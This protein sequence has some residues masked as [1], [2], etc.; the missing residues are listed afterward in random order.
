MVTTLPGAGGLAGPASPQPEVD[1]LVFAEQV[2]LLHAHA[3]VAQATV[4]VNALVVTAVLWHASAHSASVT[5]LVVV[6]AVAMARTLVARRYRRRARAPGE[7]RTWARVFVAGAAVNGIGWGAAA[8]LFHQP[9]APVHDMFIAFVLGGMTAGAASSNAS[10]LPAFAAFALPALA[11]ITVRFAGTHDHIHAAMAFMLALFGVAVAAIAR[12]GSRAIVNAIRLRLH[13]EALLANLGAAQAHLQ[14]LNADLERRVAERTAELERIL[15][16]RLESEAR[17][18]RFRALLDQTGDAILVARA[19]DLTIVDANDG[20]C[21]LLGARAGDLVGQHLDALGVVPS[22]QG[23]AALGVVAAIRPSEV[24][25]FEDRR[26]LPDGSARTF[27]MGL[28][29]R[30][31]ERERYVLL[32]ARDVSTRKEMEQQLA[33]AGLLASVGS[34]AAGVAHEIN[35]PLAYVLA[36]LQHLSA[37]IDGLSAISREERDALLEVA[38]EAL[39]GAR[40]ARGIVRDLSSLAPRENPAPEPVDLGDVL[41]PC[42]NVAMN[43]IRHRATLVRELA[44]VPA[45][46]GD[47]TRL[48]QVFLNLLVNAA[49]AVPEGR[50]ESHRITVRSRYDPAEGLVHV[51]VAD[52]GT[53][54]P[55]A[56]LGRIFEPFFTTKP[57]GHGT[58]L[59]LSICRGIVAAIGGRIAVQSREGEGS[60]FTVSLRAAPT[61]VERQEEPAPPAEE[62][63]LERGARVL[64]IDDDPAVARALKRA[65]LQKDVTIALGGEAGVAALENERF[66]VVLCDVMMPNVSGMDV[67]RRVAELRPGAERSIVFVTGGTFTAAARAFLEGL[68]NACLPKPFDVAEVRTAVRR[69]LRIDER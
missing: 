23:A 35:N 68:P 48:A 15:K 36:N 61:G 39:D 43:E 24:R 2:A 30:E 53:G 47:R 25:T 13:N 28:A 3:P 55:A 26:A 4:V 10:Y 54:I 29:V 9:D 19:E 21:E 56:H 46:V 63:D 27:E 57:V 64:V 8:L 59:G 62:S 50:P 45:V 37:S 65:L 18:A 60:T 11:P 44:S 51:D 7:V 14:Q 52:T 20:A 12:T 69:A 41:E 34:L 16:L 38:R 22:L 40:R 31:V 33:Q 67:H 42:I 1:D 66:D 17:L 32:V 58:G 5:W 6:C 49:Q